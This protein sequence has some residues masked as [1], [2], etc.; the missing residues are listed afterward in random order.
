LVSHVKGRIQVE[1]FEN[2]VLRRIFGP[3][4]DEATRGRTL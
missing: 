2:R 3:Q 4:R 1:G